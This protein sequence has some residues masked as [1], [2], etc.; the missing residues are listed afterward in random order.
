MVNRLR[1]VSDLIRLA[2]QTLDFRSPTSGSPRGE[3]RELFHPRFFAAVLSEAPL[4]R[5]VVAAR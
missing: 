5:Q 1:G 3:E 2:A 4:I